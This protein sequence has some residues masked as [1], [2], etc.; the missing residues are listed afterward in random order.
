MFH[1][2]VRPDDAQVRPLRPLYVRSPIA[3]RIDEATDLNY[4]PDDAIKDKIIPDRDSA[5]FASTVTVKKR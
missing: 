3:R 4:L 2:L 1:R 5:Y